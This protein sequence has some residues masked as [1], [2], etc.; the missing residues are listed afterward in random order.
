MVKICPTCKKFVPETAQKCPICGNTKLVLANVPASSPVAST[1]TIATATKSATKKKSK[2]PIIIFALAMVAIAI[3]AATQFFPLNISLGKSEATIHADRMIEA[4]GEVTIDSEKKILEAEKAV[5]ALS[6]REYGQL[7]NLQML[8]DAR[9]TY[10]ELKEAVLD[11]K[12]K[13]AFDLIIQYA[14][15]F[16]NPASIKLMSGTASEVGATGPYAFLCISA[17][18]G[19]GATVNGYYYLSP[20]QI[21]D[22]GNSSRKVNLCRTNSEL[23]VDKINR[24]LAQELK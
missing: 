22:V 10:D 20:V 14:A 12:D 3:F 17:T 2:V 19:F 13:V 6:D 21:D 24:A 9:A 18:N 15:S 1:A 4:I 5:S 11:G 16:K 7:E 23:D 8:K